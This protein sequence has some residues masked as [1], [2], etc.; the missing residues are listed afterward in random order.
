M[1][2]NELKLGIEYNN[3]T[4]Q[5]PEFEIAVVN[6][7]NSFIKAGKKLFTTDAGGLFEAYLNGFSKEAQQ[8]YNC[9]GCR[10]FIK[11]FGDLVAISDKGE[12][13]S[14]LWDENDVPEFFIESVKVMRLLVVNSRVNGIF[15]SDE[16]ILGQP[17]TG[18]WTHLHAKLPSALVNRSRLLTSGQIAAEKKEDFHMLTRAILDYNLSV[19][20]QALT[21]IETETLYRSDK[22]QGV[23]KWFKTV[24][25]NRASVRR[26]RQKDNITW[27]EVAKAPAGFTHI[28]N[29]MV[30][31]LLADI[32]DGLSFSSVSSRFAEKMNPSNYM[33]SQS[34]PSQNSIY[35]AEKIV[36]KLGIADSLQ[37]RYAAIEEVPTLW[38]N[39][40][41]KPPMVEK[42][43]GV[44]GQIKPK[45]TVAFTAGQTLPSSVM[46]WDKFLRT[47]LPTA[48]GLEVLT[49]N[50]NRFMALITA[51]NPESENILQWD[52]PFSWY[53][54]GGVDAE[55]KRRVENAGG[56]YSNNEIRAS[57]IWDGH[58][59]LDIHCHVPS[60]GY[61][62]EIYFGHKREGNGWLDVDAN[63]GRATT[64]TPVENIRWGT[65]PEG[66]YKI[67]VHNFAER[68]KGR[69][70][71]KLELEINGQIF[72]HTGVAGGTDWED[73][74]FEFEYRKGQEPLFFNG[75]RNG[76]HVAQDAWGVSTNSFVK[77]N[78]IT[79]SPNL[80]GE[81]PVAHAG[82]HVF[83]LLDGV[84]DSSEG[85][86]RGFFNEMLKPELRQIRKTLEAFT[87]DSSI[88]CA[89]EA[90]ACGVGYSKDTEWNLTVKV[91]TGSSSRIIKIDRWD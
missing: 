38:K 89:D 67:I 75:A 34:A 46:T 86:G 14:V 10:H 29:S 45:E 53:Y 81:Q 19:V 39:K 32:A 7:F 16:A 63:G 27:L 51:I 48:N 66:A 1:C 78:A 77:V 57:L 12:I 37:R 23:T 61:R 5:Y 69:T 11:R 90:T 13:E 62:K 44:F 83:F 26:Q 60:S 50:Q 71:F 74:V 2:K 17:R 85:K 82:T 25:E 55:V 9:N 4:D 18:E 42:K 79:T 64:M 80:W 84:K 54:H 30:G 72:V 73:K 24:I 28:R 59:D 8:H 76:S 68:G 41:V 22:I 88:E 56:Q 35:E 58:T 6:R 15:I 31:T 49:D 52:N 87:A 47:V 65:A 70:P 36:E 3:D 91:T 33:R 21:L 40:G 43:A 20:D